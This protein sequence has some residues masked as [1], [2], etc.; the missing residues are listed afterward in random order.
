MDLKTMLRDLCSA[1]GVN[2]EN[3]AAHVAK[4]YLSA[5]T[6]N[7]RTDVM[8]NVTGFVPA[9]VPGAPTLLLEA[10][11]DEIGFVVT[12]IDSE[13]FVRV[14]NCGGIDNRTLAAAEVV[15]LTEPIIYGVFCSTPP[16]LVKADEP[17]PE[18]SARGIDVGLSKKEAEARIPVGTRVM[19]RPHFDELLGDRV[20]AKAIDDRAGI[21]SILMALELVKGNAL[22]CNIAVS[23]C[24]Q[25]EIGSHGAKTA[26]FGLTLDAAIAVDVSFAHSHGLD[27]SKCGILGKGV[28]IGQ[29][30]ILNKAMTTQL[31]VLA[32]RTDI[33]YQDEVMGSHTGTDA[34]AISITR[35]GIPCAL[36][37]IPLKYMHT[38]VEVVSLGDV[39]STAKLI[40]AYILEG[41]VPTHG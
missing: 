11:I 20:S 33:P 36:L 30:P 9:A 41:E 16:H 14:T 25:E 13:G 35:T 26:A 1:A 38:P 21:A 8:G 29:S 2:G 6:E 15:I 28:M 22:P 18:L 4:K 37:S 7:I 24:T 32:K 10:H 12:G 31:I 23:F 17:L 5:Y 19:F 3:G 39:E 40:A 27:K 34:D